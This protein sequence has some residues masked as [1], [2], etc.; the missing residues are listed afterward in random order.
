[1]F[2]TTPWGNEAFL[3]HHSVSRGASSR[4]NTS[5]YILSPM[6]DQKGGAGLWGPTGR[7]GPLCRVA[8]GRAEGGYHYWPGLSG[9]RKADS[10]EC[11]LCDIPT[12]TWVP[13][14][15]LISSWI[16]DLSQ[17]SSL[18]RNL[19]SDKNLDVS[20]VFLPYTRHCAKSSGCHD[21]F[22]PDDDLWRCGVYYHPILSYLF[23]FIEVFLTYNI[24]LVPEYTMYSD[25]TILYITQCSPG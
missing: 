7:Q 11:P 8:G 4:W 9:F 17:F 16:L 6:G 12:R 13:A 14:L 25:S 10:P 18:S 3:L 21:S 1:M 20:Y 15:T 24:I 22:H 23:I 2:R 5:R 19:F